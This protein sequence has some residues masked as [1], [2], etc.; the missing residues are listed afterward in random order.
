MT[1]GASEPVSA[2]TG[3]G[4]PPPE[5]F[6]QLSTV[7]ARLRACRRAQHRLMLVLSGEAEWTA[8]RARIIVAALPGRSTIWLSDRPGQAGALPLRSA[9]R[10]PGSELGLLVYDAQ[11][12]FDPD[13]FGA[14]SGTLVGGGLLMLLTPPLAAWSEQ[15]DPQAE[16]IAVW[17][18]RAE[19]LSGHF[20]RRLVRVL[21]QDPHLIHIEQAGT[22]LP[23]I[24][25]PAD[26]IGMPQARIDR[27][28]EEAAPPAAQP[29]RL[30]APCTHDQRA[31]VA[32]I[33]KTARGRAHR[34]LVLKAHRGR[35]KSAALGL[36]AGA[37]L[38]EDRRPIL[39]TAPRRS[40]V[41]S[42][43][44]HAAAVLAADA[45]ERPAPRA[46]IQDLSFV[47]PG[48]LVL[49][50]P[51]A[52]LLLV[53]EAAGI[54]GPLLES[55]LRYYA[56]IVFATT[57]HGYEGTGRGFDL[58][59]RERLDQLTPDWRGLTLETPIRWAADDPLEAL[60]FDALLLDAAPPADTAV[61]TAWPERCELQRI[62]QSSLAED[63]ATLRA[64]F[65]LLVLAHY[66][67]RPM[68][69]RMLLDGPSVRLLA[70][71]HQGALVATL[72]A[73][74]EGGFTRPALREAI[75]LG[76]RRPRGHLLPQT[77]S[78]HAGLREAPALRYLRVIRIAVHPAARGRGLGRMLLEALRQDAEQEGMDLVGASFG[79]TPELLRF[80]SRCGQRPVQIG[81]SR[82]AA[83]GE[84]A[85][86]VLAPVTPAGGAFIERAQSRLEARLG[87]LLAGPLRTLDPGVAL[88]LLSLL[89]PPAVAEPDGCA[90]PELEQELA[91][92]THGHRTLDASLPMLAERC[93]RRLAGALARGLVSDEQAR[94]LIAA[95]RQL[96]PASELA[97]LFGLSGRDELLRRLREAARALAEGGDGGTDAAACATEVQAQRE[98]DLS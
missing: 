37:L 55:L 12:G 6:P 53:D 58:R 51:P 15:P 10:L 25:T 42:L 97:G 45:A 28:D 91:A 67:T 44:R 76:Q 20:I 50:H 11:G 41:E 7:L 49:E 5:T 48:D 32:A 92:F 35:G 23:R 47:A 80:W 62:P 86:V 88:A 95:L 65:G 4:H 24:A 66:Q 46:D 8:A 69:L 78:A 16:R 83:S 75:Y 81:C 22:S 61:A 98:L 54:P 21:E 18:H 27:A 13:G 3:L 68:D 2:A 71:R 40:A 39:V 64:V 19:T 43:Y 89:P 84:H 63:D 9:H 90:A 56:R 72:V 79:A 17:P 87:V 60:T 70:L 38:L 31:A 59:F 96:R 57:V 93:R 77:L 1:R 73:A 36:A 52:D 14:A 26:P 82:N 94:L 74:A 30:T 85:A 33:L 34:P 29:D